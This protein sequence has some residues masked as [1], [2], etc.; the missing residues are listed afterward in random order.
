LFFALFVRGDAVPE[1]LF[2]FVIPRRF[3]SEESAFG[4]FVTT[5]DSSPAETGVG[6][7]IHT[8][9]LSAARNFA[10]RDRGLRSIS[11]S[12]GVTGFFTSNR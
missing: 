6:M 3:I 8:Q 12:P 11:P 10:L 1:T 5:A 2:A 7:T 4:R 9:T